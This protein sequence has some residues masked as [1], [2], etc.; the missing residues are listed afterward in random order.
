MAKLT[1][2]RLV[3]C[4]S[5]EDI[6]YEFTPGLNVIRAEG[7]EKGKSVFF[8]M[9]KIATAPDMY[10]NERRKYLIRDGQ[11]CA[12]AVFFFDNGTAGAV[13]VYEKAVLFSY[14][15]DSKSFSAQDTRPD[16][17]FVKNLSV[18]GKQGNTGN[19]FANIID[20]KNLLFINTTSRSQ[21][22]LIELITKHDELEAYI[23]RVEEK[24]EQYNKYYPE[25]EAKK[26]RFQAQLDNLTYRD[27]DQ[28][29][30]EILQVEEYMELYELILTNTEIIENLPVVNKPGLDSELL[31][32][33]TTLL[34][35]F[36]SLEVSI[37]SFTALPEAII[38]CC[39]LALDL[40]RTETSVW[41]YNTV[42]EEINLLKTLL[43]IDVS[44][45]ATETKSSQIKS[46]LDIIEIAPDLYGIASALEGLSKLEHELEIN[47]KNRAE[48]D[49]VLKELGKEVECPIYGRV[50][51][52]KGICVPKNTGPAL[53]SHKLS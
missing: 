49:L 1:K 42:S 9:V 16:P 51:H 26:A 43:S 40:L 2:A 28:I 30:R 52:D 12:I 8:K 31:V 3:N 15:E 5:I 32:D 46:L 4:Q 20:M 23:M 45:L 37:E 10:D 25:V 17:R 47:N 35:A 38:D 21:W 22:D 36:S 13:T 24:M 50:V 53:V 33:C 6:T 41:Y 34:S 18:V 14:S 44:D 27:V 29:E 48:L 7:N 11:D 19:I 39:D